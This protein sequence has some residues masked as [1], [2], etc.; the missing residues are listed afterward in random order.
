LKKPLAT[1]E[2]IPT[3]QAWRAAASSAR[4][5]SRAARKAGPS[6]KN[7]IPKVL[8]VSRPKGMAVTSVRAVRRASRKAIQVNNRSPTTTPTA[9]PGT[10]WPRANSAG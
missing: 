8:G 4:P 5:P 1:I 10:K 2:H 3:C 7:T 6:T 9:V